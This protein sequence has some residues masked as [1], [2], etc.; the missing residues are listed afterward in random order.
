MIKHMKKK[1][2]KW[3]NTLKG[4]IIEKNHNYNDS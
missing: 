3:E 2:R 1:L 4:M